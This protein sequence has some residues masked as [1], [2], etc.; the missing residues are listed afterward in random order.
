[1]ST[2]VLIDRSE[3]FFRATM[4]VLRRMSKIELNLSIR[5]QLPNKWS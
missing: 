3:N 2:F 5:F 1:M 4:L